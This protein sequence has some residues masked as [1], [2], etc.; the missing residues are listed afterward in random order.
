M[1]VDEHCDE[2]HDERVEPFNN[3]QNLQVSNKDKSDYIN[4]KD[5]TDDIQESEGNSHCASVNKPNNTNTD[6]D[7]L[8]TLL[9]PPQ[10]AE[11]V[12]VY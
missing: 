7:V 4:D 11:Y 8:Q 12:E 10:T 9:M 6:P 2:E 3:E 5:K 1:E